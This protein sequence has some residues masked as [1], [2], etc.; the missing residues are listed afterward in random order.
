MTK[1]DLTGEYYSDGRLE[2]DAIDAEPYRIGPRI[3]KL[4]GLLAKLDPRIDGAR[5]HAIPATRPSARI[6]ASGGRFLARGI[7]AK[8]YEAGIVQRTR[9]SRV[10]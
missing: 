7:P 9:A 4:R 2:R 5:R 8:T 3:D 10:R 6:L 1:P